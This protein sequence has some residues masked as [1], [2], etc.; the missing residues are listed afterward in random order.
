MKN[1]V[2]FGF[3]ITILVALIGC[4]KEPPAPTDESIDKGHEN[5]DRVEFI[6]TKV[7][8]NG[9]DFSFTDVVQKRIY[10]MNGV[11]GVQPQGDD[12][13]WEAGTHY[14]LEIIYYNKA[15][16]RM[17]GE[18]VTAEMAPI[19]QHFFL[20]KGKKTEQMNAIV[21]YTYRDTNPESGILGQNGVT[22]RKRSWDKNNPE[23]IDPIGLKGI[24]SVKQEI[25]KVDLQVTLAHFL[26]AERG[27]NK[28]K[29]GAIQNYN[30]LPSSN[31]FSSDATV[32]IPINI[33]K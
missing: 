10:Q 26:G 7:I 3:L 25:G 19:H 24:F 23:A 2:R 28:L 6:F 16:T 20:L 31:F 32:I 5:P 21:T 11:A 27:F 14:H 4:S 1:I 8:K 12:I 13:V 9:D 17:N 33:N 29:D 30:E 15:G 22:L 18:F